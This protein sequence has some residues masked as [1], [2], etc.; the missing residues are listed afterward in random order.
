MDRITGKLSLQ[1]ELAKVFFISVCLDV[2][3]FKSASVKFTS[4]FSVNIGSVIQSPV[5]KVPWIPSYCD[6]KSV[7]ECSRIGNLI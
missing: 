1:K 7:K 5:T 6:L 4:N 3:H 2:H